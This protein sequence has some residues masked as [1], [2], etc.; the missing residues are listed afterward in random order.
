M[1]GWIILGSILLL[2]VILMMCPVYLSVH[3][4]DENRITLGYLFIKYPLYPLKLKQKEVKEA[5]TEETERQEK[6]IASEK[7]TKAKVKVLETIQMILDLAKASASPL[8]HL[9]RR[10][11]LVYLDVYLDVGG[12]DAAEIAMNTTKYRA[13]ISYFIG[14]FRNLHLLKRMKRVRIAP[15]FLKE[16]TEYKVSFCLMWRLSTILYAVLAA[17]IKYVI[18]QFKKGSEGELQTAEHSQKQSIKK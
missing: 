5:E 4:E 17:V 12:E 3:L 14:L 6:K 13:T 11:Y 15:N 2:L 10:T 1:A 18:L 7:K 16:E 8:F 9:L